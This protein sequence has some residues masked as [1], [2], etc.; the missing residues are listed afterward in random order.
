MTPRDDQLPGAG[1]A[2]GGPVEAAPPA[3]HGPDHHDRRRPQRFPIHAFAVADFA[4][5]ALAGLWSLAF[6]GLLLW[7]AFFA[8]AESEE[9]SLGLAGSLVL[10]VIGLAAAMVFAA[11]GYGLLQRRPWGYYTHLVAVALVALTCWGIPYSIAAILFAARPEF[12]APFFRRP[13]PAAAVPA[14]AQP[15]A[16][17]PGDRG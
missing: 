15:A 10:V 4:L 14:V 16:P 9:V 1:M 13:G 5:A 7:G 3:G 11:A 17:A 12:R 8:E 6:L 2:A